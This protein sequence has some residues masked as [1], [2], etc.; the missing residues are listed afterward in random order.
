MKGEHLVYFGPVLVAMLYLTRWC[1]CRSAEALVFE[2][3]L[4]SSPIGPYT[5][6]SKQA[7]L[8]VVGGKR[9]QKTLV[10]MP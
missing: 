7:F 1:G 3:E 8:Q 10:A 4:A 9:N 2:V 5:T 6:I